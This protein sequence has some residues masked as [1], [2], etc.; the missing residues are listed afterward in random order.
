[1]TTKTPTP[2]SFF[3]ALAELS[4]LLGA[5]CLALSLIG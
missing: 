2:R 3:A 5:G 4:V 1:M